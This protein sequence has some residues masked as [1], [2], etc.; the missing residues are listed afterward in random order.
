MSVS[1][2]CSIRTGIERPCCDPQAP[3]PSDEPGTIVVAI[4][5]AI[6]AVPDVSPRRIA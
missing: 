4:E 5:A 3:R 6:N 1:D 2:D